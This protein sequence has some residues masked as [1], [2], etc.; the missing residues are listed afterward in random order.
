MFS[1]MGIYYILVPSGYMLHNWKNTDFICGEQH[2]IVVMYVIWWLV[3]VHDTIII[4]A[5]KLVLI[6]A[7]QSHVIITK[8][9]MW[10]PIVEMDPSATMFI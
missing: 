9:R 7:V 10:A 3:S 5:I 6:L 4:K 8:I 2:E 1:Y